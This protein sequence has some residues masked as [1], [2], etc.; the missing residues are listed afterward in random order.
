MYDM[1]IVGGTVVDGTG[2]D[3][4]PRGYRHQGRQDRR[5]HAVRANGDDQLSELTRRRR[6]TRRIA[7]SRPVSST[8]TPTTTVKSLGT[9]CSSPRAVTA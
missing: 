6:S 8:F 2:A 4:L 1:K 7:S 9:A 3:R 5:S